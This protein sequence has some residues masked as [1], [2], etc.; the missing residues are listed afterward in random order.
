MPSGPHSFVIHFL[1]SFLS[2]CLSDPS[3]LIFFSENL[4]IR[5]PSGTPFI[6][7]SFVK[8]F[9]S[10]C[11]PDSL[12]FD[13]LFGNP[14]YPYAFWEH[15]HLLS[16]TPFTCYSFV[17]SFLSL[18]LSD[19]LSFDILFGNTFYPY[20][21]WDPIHLLFLCE[22]LSFLM[23]PD[24]PS[25]DIRFP[26]LSCLPDPLSFDILSRNPF[27]LYAFW[28]TYI[29]YSFVIPFFPLCLSDPL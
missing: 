28:T 13:I 19:T 10:L 16:G 4:S 24:H 17:N 20:A 2:L 25:F 9:H 26:F 22:F 7:Y 8:S 23:P 1:N 14:F 27:Y 21:F 12:S 18:C 5:M 3:H 6:C 29:C 15:I 11:L